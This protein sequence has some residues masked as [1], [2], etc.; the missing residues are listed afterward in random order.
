VG[1]FHVL[2]GD[3]RQA[4][5]ACHQALTL[6]QDL[7]DRVGQAGTWDSIGYAHHY[8]GHHTHALT[9]YERALTLFRDLGDRYGEATT[10]TH[11]GDTHHAT[12]NHQAANNAWQ[13]ALA[14]LDDLNHPD[15]EQVRA[16]LAGLDTSTVEPDDGD[17]Y[18]D[19]ERAGGT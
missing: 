4:L 14:I 1:W 7:G 17:A 11:L 3:Y 13:H 8:L 19:G 12:G 15:A 9:C 2:L 10:L 6:F 16:K 5:T 18:D